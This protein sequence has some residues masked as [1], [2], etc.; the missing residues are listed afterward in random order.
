MLR[1]TEKTLTLR[2]RTPSQIDPLSVPRVLVIPTVPRCLEKPETENLASEVLEDDQNKTRNP[3]RM[4]LSPG[5]GADRVRSLKRVVRAVKRFLRNDLG[6]AR[7]WP[8][9]LA[10]E[11]TLHVVL[12]FERPQ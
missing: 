1:P 9:R 11:I 12:A 5:E 3:L 10:G 6:R 4:T 8:Q 2:L 7:G